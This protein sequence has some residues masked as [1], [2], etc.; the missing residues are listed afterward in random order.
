MI[1]EP[2]ESRLAASRLRRSFCASFACKAGACF[3]LLLT[4][5]LPLQAKETALTAI[6]LFDGPSGPA[7][8]QI[9][10]VL[11]N[12]KTELRVCDGAATIDKR[13]YDALP[14]TTLATAA[15]LERNADG[16]LMLT[17]GTAKPVCVVPSNLKFDKI[18]SFTPAEAAEQTVLQGTILASSNPQEAGALPQL[19][20]G[21]KLVFVAA[22]DTELAEYLRAQR[23][24]TVLA[25]RDFL[26]RYSSSTRAPDARNA[27][28][29]LLTAA[30]ETAFNNYR[31]SANA[32]DVQHLK[33]AQQRAEQAVLAV[34]AYPAAQALLQQV[35]SELET[36]LQADTAQLE[37]FR[38]ALANHTP[39]YGH[40]GAAKRLNDEIIEVNPKFAAAV[41]LQNEIWQETRKLDIAL[42]AA[43]GLVAA[44]RF[45][46]ALKAVS[47]YL[48]FATEAPRIEAIQT[49]AYNDHFKH[50]QELSDKRDWEHAVTEFRAAVDI[51]TSSTEAA[52]ALKNAETELATTHNRVLASQA[53]EQSRSYAEG[54][55]FVEAYEVLASLP[56]GPRSQVS[57]QM[58][59]LAKDYTLAASRRAQ[60][61]QEV[62]VP[63]RG[64]ADE[65]AV[66]QAYDLL[67]RASALNGDPAMKLRL[68]L[69]SDKIS[70]YYIDV[71][72]R[73]LEKPLGSGVGLGWLYLAEAQRYRPDSDAVK[74]QIAKYAP[75]YQLRGRLSV[76]ILLRDQTSR[77]T[78]AGF[79]DQLADAIASGLETSGLAV[80]AVRLANDNSPALQP[81]FLLTGEILQHRVVKNEGLETLASKYRV[82]TREVK[83]EAWIKINHDYETAQQA[84]TGAQHALA[85]LQ[86]KNK[87]KEIP[88]ASDAVEAAKKQADG[89]RKQLDSTDQTR[90]ENV[91]ESYNYTRKTLDLTAIVEL[92]FRLADPAGNIVEA[93]TPV[94]QENHK[95]FILLENVK[96][97][98]TE[99]VKA[100]NAPPDE[101]QFLVDQEVQARDALIKAVREKVSHL[102]AKI[103]QDARARAQSDPEAAAAQYILYLNATP[104]TPSPE[105]DEAA[106]FLH[107]HFNLTLTRASK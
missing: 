99:G 97:E 3:L 93:A 48:P 89:L 66:R 40:L 106:R 56:D 100:Q 77:L 17:S 10:S 47:A 74:D 18:A 29:S 39:G 54:K 72:R 50:G 68:D 25:W 42:Q 69:L 7:Y 2:T 70:V 73:Y 19:K 5:S 46:D 26:S 62:H 88:A 71:A 43:D 94:K 49:A 80:K 85:D 90:P 95:T 51:R 105:R 33:V 104:D 60:K 30:A 6:A 14:R 34:P 76:G 98:D 79:A 37:A 12:G 75:A 91:I 27:I 41:T 67:S 53:L 87:K 38:K 103:L 86:A 59:A 96:P 36:L 13:A 15:S 63:I 82:G 58:A 24:N 55:Q 57:E 11:L 78:S 107:D 45:D 4:G 102:P 20:P 23:A 35:H 83:N 84:L 28:A 31:K 65:D 101:Q 52:A 21:T 16:T 22:P 9:T 61:L 8:V 44:Q 1:S 92:A 32:R 81:G 64:K